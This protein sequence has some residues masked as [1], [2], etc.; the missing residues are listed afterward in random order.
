MITSFISPHSPL[1][2]D[3]VNDVRKFAK[4]QP[5]I[6][7]SPRVVVSVL[8]S[9]T[10]TIKF[11]FMSKAQYRAQG[12]SRMGRWTYVPP[13]QWVEQYESFWSRRHG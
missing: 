4:E 2:K 8:P 13:Q 6:L 7:I 1:A 10:Q 5:D 12:L 9:R 11:H 3:C